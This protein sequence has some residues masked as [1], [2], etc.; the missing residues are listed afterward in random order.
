MPAP[1]A[2]AASA[3]VG[4][5]DGVNNLL[6]SI[7]ASRWKDFVAA[8]DMSLNNDG[9]NIL[10]KVEHAGHDSSGVVGP[11]I[12]IVGIFEESFAVVA[13]GSGASFCC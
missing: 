4:E 11:V 2:V 1:T 10:G 8:D 13:M 5:G 3:V 7:H 9:A 6:F 12:V